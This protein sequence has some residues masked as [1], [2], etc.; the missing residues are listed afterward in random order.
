MN[1]EPAQM[2][3]VSGWI[4]GRTLSVDGFWQPL[5]AS[6]E[7][8]GARRRFFSSFERNPP[9]GSARNAGYANASRRRNSRPRPQF[10]DQTQNLGKQRSW[11]SD[12]GYLKRDIAAVAHDFCADLD[13]LFL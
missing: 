8:D 7:S 5:A 2:V 6:A 11:N 12:L 9:M 3:P 4:G 13:Q 1:A 10:G